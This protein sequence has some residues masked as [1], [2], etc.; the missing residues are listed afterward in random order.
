MTGLLLALGMTL[1]SAAHAEV[2]GPQVVIQMA[3]FKGDPLGS[4]DEGTLKCLSAPKIVTLDGQTAYVQIGGQVAIP[5]PG[6]GRVTYQPTGVTLKL[7]PKVQPEGTVLLRLESQIT[8]VA[9]GRGV[10][11]SKGV[12][13]PAFNTQSVQLIRV[14]KDTESFKVRVAADSVTD[15]TWIDLTVNIVRSMPPEPR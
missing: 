14:A 7:T 3:V 9:P 11:L 13:V 4:R 8:E 6:S 10:T 15:Q 5:E 12:V 2:A 1:G